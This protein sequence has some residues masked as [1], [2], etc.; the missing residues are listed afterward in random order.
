MR[1]KFLTVIA[2]AMISA[3]T[4]AQNMPEGTPVMLS[5]DQSVSSKTARKG[6]Q[7]KFHV[8]EDVKVDGKTVIRQGTHVTGVISRVGKSGIFGK[9]GKLEFTLS[10]VKVHNHWVTLEPKS[11]GKEYKGSRTDHAAEASGG[12]LILLGPVG[13]VG[14]AFVKGKSLEI[15]PGDRLY[16]EVVRGHAHD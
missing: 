1:I 3:F 12:G 5:F 2:A 7:V 10:P 16:T 6:D 14:G 4:F 15:H 11:K 9:N 8:F 13:L